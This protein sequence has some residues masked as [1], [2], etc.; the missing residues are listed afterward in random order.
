MLIYIDVFG[1][2]VVVASIETLRLRRYAALASPYVVAACA[3]IDRGASLASIYA[4]RACVTDVAVR[5][6]N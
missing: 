3:S 1:V 4:D 5:C 6:V 2:A